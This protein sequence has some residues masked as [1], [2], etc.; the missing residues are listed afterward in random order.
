MMSS[1]MKSN[2]SSTQLSKSYK[3]KQLVWSS[4]YRFALKNGLKID[5][6]K[7]PELTKLG[8]WAKT[9]DQANLRLWSKLSRPVLIKEFCE[10]TQLT[11]ED[12]YV[13]SAAEAKHNWPIS[14]SF[15]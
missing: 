9:D 14:R 2:Q 7:H 11:P 4:I 15:N 1:S 6:K 13:N 10:I 3:G 12:F 5:V 8:Y